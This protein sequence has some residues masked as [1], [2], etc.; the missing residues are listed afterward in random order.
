[1][2]KGNA[3]MG[4]ILLFSAAIFIMQPALAKEDESLAMANASLI[5]SSSLTK[6]TVT[7]MSFRWL[8]R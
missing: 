3:L 5:A 4:V 7:E 6:H 2:R 1:M 8:M